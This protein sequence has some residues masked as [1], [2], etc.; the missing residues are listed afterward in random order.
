M[1]QL[2]TLHDARRSRSLPAARLHA[3]SA[4]PLAARP[5]AGVNSARLSAVAA[6]A[7]G[8]L[9]RSR[10]HRAVLA[11]A[12]P[13]K[14]RSAGDAGRANVDAGMSVS[15]ARSTA[16]TGENAQPVGDGFHGVNPAVAVDKGDAAPVG[17]T[18]ESDLR[19]AV[20][21]R[22]LSRAPLFF[23]CVDQRRWNR[24]LTGLAGT[25]S[26][27]FELVPSGSTI[28]PPDTLGALSPPACVVED[29]WEL[30]SID[31]DDAGPPA[32]AL[33]VPE[34][35]IDTRAGSSTR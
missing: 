4:V 34:A 24:R 33:C 29:E 28:D 30:L 12:G 15:G 20:P 25:E 18:P 21:P 8:M 32:V 6:R 1:L 7:D 11:V 14:V 13:A 16:G 10:V 26:H 22:R 17:P 5:P 2:K 3:H 9:G 31:S 19:V 23:P 27:D 35:S